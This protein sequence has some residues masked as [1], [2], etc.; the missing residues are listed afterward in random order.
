LIKSSMRRMVSAASVANCRTQNRQQCVELK[1]WKVHHVLKCQQHCCAC[2]ACG[3]LRTA[4][5]DHCCASRRDH[6]CSAEVWLAFHL[7]RNRVRGCQFGEHYD[8]SCFWAPSAVFGAQQ[9]TASN[10]HCCASRRDHYCSAEVWLAFQLS[11][12]RIRGC[13]FGE[14][15]DVS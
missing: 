2:T 13:Q 14:H 4:S 12:N 6:C 15:Y 9:P 8:V 11:W 10:G 7:S 1:R 5:H 3:L